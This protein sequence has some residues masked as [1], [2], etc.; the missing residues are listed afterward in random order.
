MILNSVNTHN[1]EH[2]ISHL[3][4]F[5]WHEYGVT[6]L[7]DLAHQQAVSEG[8]VYLHNRKRTKEPRRYYKWIERRWQRSFARLGGG[9]AG[10]G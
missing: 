4:V 3:G 2:T 9:A 1:C 6:Y 8:V 7:Y 10:G 5:E